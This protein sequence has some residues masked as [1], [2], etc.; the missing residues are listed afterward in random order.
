MY[1]VRV[2]PEIS[3]ATV[4]KA[5]GITQNMSTGN[6]DPGPMRCAA[7]RCPAGTSALVNG[8]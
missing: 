2:S 7:G 4:N 6:E 8:R 1:C 3:I 5:E